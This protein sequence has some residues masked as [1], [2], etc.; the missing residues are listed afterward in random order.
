MTAGKLLRIYL[1]ENDRFENKPLYVAVV[2]ALR[3]SGFTGA[4]VLKGIEGFGR[5]KVVHSA[6]AVD[7]STNLPVVVEVVEEVAMGDDDDVVHMYPLD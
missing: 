7:Y 1:T 5:S 2:G 6:R 3:A 4:T